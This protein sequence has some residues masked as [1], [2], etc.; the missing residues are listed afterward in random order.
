MRPSLLKRLRGVKRLREG[1]GDI[2]NCKRDLDDLGNLARSAYT[3]YFM[4][5]I[6]Y[7]PLEVPGFPEFAQGVGYGVPGT[8]YGCFQFFGQNESLLDDESFARREL[9]EIGGKHGCIILE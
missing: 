5:T 9:L 2:V 1:E 3:S 8:P 4:K 7:V 6:H